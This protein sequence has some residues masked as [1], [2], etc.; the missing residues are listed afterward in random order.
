MTELPLYEQVN[1]VQSRDE[2]I[3]LIYSLVRNLEPN[4]EGWEN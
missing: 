3:S 4:P 2:A 1:R